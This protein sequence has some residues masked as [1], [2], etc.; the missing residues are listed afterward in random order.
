[1]SLSGDVAELC[2]LFEPLERLRERLEANDERIE[3]L[4]ALIEE[5]NELIERLTPPTEILLPEDDGFEYFLDQLTLKSQQ[6]AQLNDY[7]AAPAVFSKLKRLQSSVLYMHYI[8]LSIVDGKENSCIL[9]RGA[10]T[11]N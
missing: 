1:M 6:V 7:A 10:E 2:E 3:Q 4:Q 8:N 9:Y 11:C 5:G